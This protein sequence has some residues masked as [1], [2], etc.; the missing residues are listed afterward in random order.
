MECDEVGRLIEQWSDGVEMRRETM[1][2]L[3]NHL[4]VCDPCRH[5]YGTLF[6]IIT[7]REELPAVDREFVDSV[8]ERIDADAFLPVPKKGR[9]WVP[10]A[11]AAMVAFFAGFMVRGNFD[12]SRPIEIQFTF[13]DPEASSVRLVGSFPGWE[14]DGGK[15]MR[16]G[17]DGRWELAVEIP[18]Q[19][20]YTYSFLIDGTVWVPDPTSEEIVD[21]GFGGLSS[22][23]RV[24]GKI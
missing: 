13:V 21:D 9:I 2:E 18:E 3:R 10:L 22:L 20:V 15:E 16:K 7:A 8:M 1:Y 5:R 6:R 12:V 17:E 23:L 24:G 11:A 14:E 19:G 4:E